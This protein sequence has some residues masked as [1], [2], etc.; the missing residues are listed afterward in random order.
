M[1][2]KRKQRRR[3]IVSVAAI[4]AGFAL[5]LSL[6]NK[7]AVP[8]AAQAQPNPPMGWVNDPEAVKAVV[9][10]LPIKSFSQTPAF[11]GPDPDQVFLWEAERKVLGHT[12]P[13]RNQGQVG[14]CVS[15]GAAAAVE[16]LMCVQIAIEGRGEEFKDVAQEVIYGGS[17]IEIGGGRIRG[18][19]SVGAWA[20][21][22]CQKYGVVARG[23][24]GNVDLSQYSEQTCRAFGRNGV[25][26]DLETIAR[27]RPVKSIVPVATPDECRK[28]LASGYPVTV[29]SDQGF[30]M[31]RDRDGFCKA[32]GSW[33]HQM[34][35]I[36][37]QKGSRPGFW[38][39][40]S[41]GADAFT[42]PVG[43]GNPPDGG[44]WAEERVVARM[45]AQGDSWAY[46]DLNGF[47]GRQ[48]NEWFTKAVPSS[49][50]RFKAI[51]DDM[52][53]LAP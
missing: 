47:P 45:L 7:P 2:E 16:R 32:S 50:K 9:G 48:L 14:S 15:F 21:Q 23:V 44:F 31:V 12:I 36:G 10:S 17:R 18:D 40:N 25:P 42:G 8:P 35:I 52:F 37:Y 1:F 11:R 4:A 30:T 33:G 39:Q 41:W 6:I 34:C 19:G 53:A 5:L 28:A 43:A 51:S 22:W 46:G 24:Y 38:I 49:Q 29:A 13:C 3:L 20:A 27:Q 26:P